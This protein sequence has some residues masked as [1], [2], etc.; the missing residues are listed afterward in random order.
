MLFGINLSRDPEVL[1]SNGKFYDAIAVFKIRR[2]SEKKNKVGMNTF[3]I[4]KYIIDKHV[5]LSLNYINDKISTDLN[6]QHKS[7]LYFQNF[8][9]AAHRIIQVKKK[10]LKK[11]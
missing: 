8:R 5:S 10:K 6:K 1:L 11:K 9:T 4:I 2:K 3:N 7:Y